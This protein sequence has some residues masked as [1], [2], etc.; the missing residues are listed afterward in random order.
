MNRD[1]DDLKERILVLEKHN[2]SLRERNQFLRQALRSLGQKEEDYR[3]RYE[4]LIR[5]LDFCL[6]EDDYLMELLQ[7]VDLPAPVAQ[8]LRLEERVKEMLSVDEEEPET[9][10]QRRLRE[11]AWEQEWHRFVADHVVKHTTVTRIRVANFLNPGISSLAG[12]VGRAADR[13]AGRHLWPVRL[14]IKL[15]DRLES[16]FRRAHNFLDVLRWHIL[17]GG[18]KEAEKTRDYLARKYWEIMGG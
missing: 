17:F 7:R 3:E 13:L 4:K 18:W 11:L 5:A 1:V 15:E 10:E 8:D 16:I 12:L 14:L 9:E 6:D 2:S